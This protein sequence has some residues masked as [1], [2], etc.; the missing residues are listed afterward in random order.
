MPVTVKV[1][2]D[3]LNVTAYQAAELPTLTPDS[4]AL[5]PV[6]NVPM[7]RLLAQL[8]AGLGTMVGLVVGVGVTQVM[9]TAP[10]LP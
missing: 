7:A 8:L 5:V 4:V 1:K 2:D 9:L 10:P 3:V 6:P